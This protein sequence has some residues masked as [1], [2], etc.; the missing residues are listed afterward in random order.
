MGNRLITVFT[1]L[2]HRR[3]NQVFLQLPCG[4]SRDLCRCPKELF[5]LPPSQNVQIVAVNLKGAFFV[6]VPCYNIGPGI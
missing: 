1:P 6:S 4:L 5:F 3:C 2:L